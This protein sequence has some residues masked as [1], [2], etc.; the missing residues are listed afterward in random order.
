MARVR[1]NLN[2]HKTPHT[3]VATVVIALTAV[4]GFIGLGSNVHGLSD[5]LY[6]PK[7]AAHA[8]WSQ[9]FNKQPNGVPNSTI[10][11]Y[12]TGTAVP[13]LNNEAET[14]TNSSE[15]ARIADGK[16]LIEAKQERK[17]GQNYTSAY[18]TTKDSFVFTYGRLDVCMKLP[19]GVGTWP[20]AW[21]W[22]AG[23]KYTPENVGLSQ[24]DP[25]AWILNGELDIAEG[26]GA[27]PGQIFSSAHTYDQVRRNPMATLTAQAVPD[28]TSKYHCYGIVKTPAVISFTLDGK[29]FYTL[30]KP[31]VAT[32]TNWPFDQPYY[33]IIN[34]A[35]GG[36][37]GG[38]KRAQFPPDGVNN[39]SGPWTLSVSRID[40]YPIITR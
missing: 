19:T 29:V 10:W 17:D 28:D 5:L 21:L 12:V 7:F 20:A 30:Q 16:L 11:T 15:N 24:N 2:S 6:Q 35:M 8:A 40:Y 14:Y 27:E 3:R 37:W 33:L 32:P 4:L 34:L 26:V 39:Q 13:G 1:H 22:P 36:S 9:D 31:K 25:N 23:A 38:E 18:L